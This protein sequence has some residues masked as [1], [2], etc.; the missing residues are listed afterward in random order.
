MFAKKLAEKLKA[1]GIRVFSIDPGG[2]YIR[3]VNVLEIEL[4]TPPKLFNLDCRDISRKTFK[5]R[6]A[7]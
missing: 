3:S 5:P 6:S 4:L 1:K 2:T 7:R